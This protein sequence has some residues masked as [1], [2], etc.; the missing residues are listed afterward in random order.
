[1]PLDCFRIALEVYSL[2]REELI[3]EMGRL[4]EGRGLW[5]NPTT[6]GY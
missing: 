2:F 5:A 1:M 6:T 4:D 3:D